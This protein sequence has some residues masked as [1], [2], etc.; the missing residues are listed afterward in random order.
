MQIWDITFYDRYLKYGL[1]TKSEF[2]IDKLFRFY[3]SSRS[4]HSMSSKGDLYYHL[5]L[6]ASDFVLHYTG[7]IKDL[8][9]EVVEH[10]ADL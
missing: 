10:R 9:A 6:T 4:H 8:M 7:G 5:G 3:V 1:W 2:F